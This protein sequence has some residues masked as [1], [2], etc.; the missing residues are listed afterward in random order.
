MKKHLLAVYGTLRKGFGNNYLLDS[1]YH[2][3]DFITEPNFTMY[4]LGFFPA[5]IPEGNTEIYLEIYLVSDIVLQSIYSLEGYQGVRGSK[6]NFYDTMDLETPWGKA[7]M[8]I[9]GDE[10]P[11]EYGEKIENGKW[12]RKRI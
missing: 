3:G 9:F 1:S 7:E 8:F 4:D 5:V 11:S 12:T 10:I 6:E 2:L